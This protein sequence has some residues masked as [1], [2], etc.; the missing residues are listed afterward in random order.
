LTAERLKRIRL[1][2]HARDKFEFLRRYGFDISEV[3]VREAVAS[4]S[5]V[6]RRDDELLALK[7][8]DREYAIRVVYKMVNGNIVVL[9][10]YPVKRERFNV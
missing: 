6:D 10:F 3:S 4:P 5:R 7:P 8:L 1:T 9:T 2:K